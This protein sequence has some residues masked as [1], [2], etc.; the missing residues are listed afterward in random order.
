MSA[1][2]EETKRLQLDADTKLEAER[3]L[4][5]QIESSQSLPPPMVSPTILASKRAK[6]TSILPSSSLPSALRSATGGGRKPKHVMFQL[7]DLKV[8]EPSSSY[9]EGPSPDVIVEEEEPAFDG[10]RETPHQHKSRQPHGEK[11]GDEATTKKGAAGGGSPGLLG[12]KKSKRRGRSGRFIS[13]IP[14]PLPS[15]N[16]SPVIDGT[17]SSEHNANSSVAPPLSSPA[18]LLS[19]PTES[20]FSGG[21]FGAEDGGSG[22]GF[23]ELDEELASPALRDGKVPTFDFETGGDPG[24]LEDADAPNPNDMRNGN[25]DTNH[26]G[27]FKAGSVPIDIV[28][29]TGSWVG[30]FGH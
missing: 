17:S 27:S 29:P 19:S 20:G 16:P 1:Q 9:E 14:S 30:S 21:L 25:R 5:K 12:D 26:I 8:V 7:A 2:D 4:Q 15:P 11:R 18:L 24:F 23:F 13:P 3:Q 22:V 10:N 28:R 6:S